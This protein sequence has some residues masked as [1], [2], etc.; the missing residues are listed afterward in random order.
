MSL[1]QGNTL[2]KEERIY[3]KKDIGRLLADGRFASVG[4]LRFCQMP[5]EHDFSRMMVSV[6]KKN[7]KRAVKRNLLKRR[8]RESFRTRKG[9]LA[10]NRDILFIYTSKEIHSYEEISAAMDEIIQRLNSCGS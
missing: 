6:P 1:Q 8:I 2:S 5:N 3:C 7:F 9:Q 10:T 4:F